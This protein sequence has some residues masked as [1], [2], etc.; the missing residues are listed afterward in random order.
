MFAKTIIDSDAFLDMPLSTQALYFHLSMRGDD[1]G[2][3]NNP[4]KIQRMVGATDDD[5]KL[6]IA[7]NFIIPFESGVVVIKHWKIH[8]YIRNDR[9]V[10]TKYQEEKKLLGIKENGAYTFD[11]ELKVIEELSATDKRKMAYQDSTLPYSFTYKMKRAFEDCKCP[12]C[13]MRM[14]TSYTTA[15]PT[16]QHNV[17]ISKGGVHELENISVI[18]RSCNSSIRD[19]ETEELN[20][21]EVIEKWDC[22]I[23]AEKLKID[24]FKKPEILEEIKCLSSDC[25]MSVACTQNVGIG[26]VRLVK[27]SLDKDNIN[28]IA[29]SVESEPAPKTKKPQ[30]HKYGEYNNVL[31]T[32]EEMEKL[33]KEFPDI[34]ERIERLSSYVASTGKPYKSHYAT[35]RNW[36]RKDKEQPQKKNQF[37]NFEQRNRSSNEMNA[38]ERMLLANNRAVKVDDNPELKAEADA[39]KAELESKYGKGKEQ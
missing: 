37:N 12:V 2:F 33:K 11:S 32:D 36:A 14:T 13:N 20:N 22:I 21:R 30:K 27:D 25:Q 23:L 29:D 10:E 1:E 7:K 28:I 24:W 8:N 15:T 9:L 4:K 3:I 6:L 16:I 19:T 18:C 35:I 39:L 34:D 17:P 26:K 31:L 38:L 5:I